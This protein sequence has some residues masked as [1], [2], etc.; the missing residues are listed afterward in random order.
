MN[1]QQAIELLH[2]S[3]TPEDVACCEAL[4]NY[5]ESSKKSLYVYGDFVSAVDSLGLRDA[6]QNIQRCVNILKT[7]KIGLLRQEYR[8]LD[9]DD[10]IYPVKLEDL[11]AAYLE[12]YLYLDWRNASDSDY[13]SKI[14]IVFCVNEAA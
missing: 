8:Y 1:K 5:I 3:G 11:Q 14:Y 7:K 4:L 6:I 9:D 10:V 12:G 2:L 13:A